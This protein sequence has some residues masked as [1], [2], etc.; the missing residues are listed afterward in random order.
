MI[1]MVFENLK[2]PNSKRSTRK[3]PALKG[4]MLSS[5]DSMDSAGR[6]ATVWFR[7]P[8]KRNWQP[9]QLI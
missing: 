5:N 9:L 1:L 6:K 8:N 4:K 2:N 7:C 3:E